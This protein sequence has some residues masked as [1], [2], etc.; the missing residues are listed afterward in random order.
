MPLFAEARQS[1]VAYGDSSLKEGAF[2]DCVLTMG[3]EGMQPLHT[4]SPSRAGKGRG[5]RPPWESVAEWVS[6]CGGNNP[7]L[8]LQGIS[9]ACTSKT[10]LSHGLRRDSSF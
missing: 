5:D 4:F 2:W 1:S 7:Q 6:R 8:S 9:G 3:G 10:I